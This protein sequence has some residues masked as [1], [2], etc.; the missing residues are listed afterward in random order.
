MY[1]AKRS[2]QCLRYHVVIVQAQWRMRRAAISYCKIHSAT[3]LIQTYTRA[4]AMA[5]RERGKYISLR[6][7]AVEIQRG[8]R[9]WRALR[10]ARKRRAAIVI[11]AAFRK[12]HLEKETQRS[13][14]ALKIQSWYRMLRCVRQFLTLR[15]SAVLIQALFRGR[16]QRSHLQTLML[17]QR[18]TLV[19]Q[20]AFRGHAVR[21]HLA[22][23]RLAAVIVQRWFRA[24]V[25]RNLERQSFLTLKHAA[26]TMQALHRGNT[27]RG[28]LRKKCSAVTVIQ[29]AFRRFAAE[30]RF[31]ALKTATTVIQ[32]WYRA[33]ILAHKTREEYKALKGSA[34][35]IQRVWRGRADRKRL[36]RLHEYATL[37]QASYRRHRAQELYR[38]TKL[39]AVV[40]QY[41]FRACMARKIQRAEYL[42]LKAAAIT[43]QANF[44]GMK[45]RMQLDRKHR[46]ATLIQSVGRMAATAGRYKH[47]SRLQGV[48]S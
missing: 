28:F 24:C 10:L 30:R 46:A 6:T 12:W 2:Y 7:A 26:I 22:K 13:A 1:S 29:A 34:V 5:R 8:F 41:H 20:S 36:E 48:S 11:Q 23:K 16:A 18:S 9:R 17:Q 43:L 4:W 40:L 42:Q 33:M 21:K 35:V 15:T 31:L 37:I 25:K 45:V 44:R 19:I 32:Q 14:A 39:A 3:T 47:S 27:A 38:S